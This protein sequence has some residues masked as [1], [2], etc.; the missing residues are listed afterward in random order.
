[1][2]ECITSLKNLPLQN[3]LAFLLVKSLIAITFF[4]GLTLAFGKTFNELTG[5]PGKSRDEPQLRIDDNIVNEI[6]DK[7]TFA[8]NQVKPFL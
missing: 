7:I 4:A 3:P 2:P 1:V 8:V 6:E 5:S